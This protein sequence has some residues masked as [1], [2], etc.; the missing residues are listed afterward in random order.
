LPAREP[1]F[2]GDLANRHVEI[3]IALRRPDHQKLALLD[4]QTAERDVAVKTLRH[5]ARSGA[6]APPGGA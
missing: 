1:Q 4:G 6:G 3:I 2:L 5:E